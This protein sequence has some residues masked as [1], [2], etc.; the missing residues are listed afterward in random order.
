MYVFNRFGQQISTRNSLTNTLLYNFS[1]TA[2]SHY[3]KLTKVSDSV[4]ENSITVRR[5]YRLQ[6]RELVAP[7]GGGKCKLDLDA[8]GQLQRFAA[9]VDNMTTRFSYFGSR[10]KL[11][12]SIKSLDAVHNKYRFDI[13]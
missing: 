1:Y 3:G 12:C 5:D 8:M 2:Q 11:Y 4:A 13:P 6:A 9:S 10:W 7:S